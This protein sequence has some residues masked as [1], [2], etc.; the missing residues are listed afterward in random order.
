MIFDDKTIQCVDCKT[1]F[2]FTPGSRS[3][4]RLRASLMSLSVVPSAAG[5][6]KPG[7][8]IAAATPMRHGIKYT[9]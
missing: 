1:N 5:L 4:T 9:E 3:S 2:T 6:T 8:P 7:V